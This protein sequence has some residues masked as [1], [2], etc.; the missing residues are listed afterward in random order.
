MSLQLTDPVRSTMQALTDGLKKILD[1][2]LLGVYLGGSV[3]MGDFCEASSDLDFL[4]VTQDRLSQEDALAVQLLHKDLL[5]RHPY[6]ARLEGDYAPRQVLV[7]EGTSEPVPGC[8]RGKFLPRVGEIMLSADNIANMRDAGITFFGPQAKEVLPSV[9]ADQV[10][11][12]VR[13]MLS[14]GT[15]PCESAAEAATAL[16]NLLRSAC[17]LEQGRPV[18]KSEGAAW[19]LAH[20][21]PEW[22]EPVQT[23][24][25]VRCGKEAPGAAD[26][27][28]KA[29]PKLE[30]LVRERFV[31]VVN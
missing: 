22:Q 3:A 29:V 18:T 10:R 11:A 14:Q 9:T 1:S 21:G 30:Q 25:A 7:P 15:D 13:M 26:L 5:R 19:G 6:A 17:A 23:A 27:L 12:A 31:H 28:C 2:K 20:L 8:E 4:V 16:L 24:L